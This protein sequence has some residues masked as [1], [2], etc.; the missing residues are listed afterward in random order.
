MNIKIE[1]TRL[2]K[3]EV[4]LFLGSKNFLKNQEIENKNFYK[5]VNWEHGRSTLMNEVVALTIAQQ[6]DL[7]RREAVIL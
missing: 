6:N 5:G 7:E 4:K 3:F 1:L 2:K